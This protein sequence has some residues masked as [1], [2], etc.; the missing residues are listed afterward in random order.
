MGHVVAQ[1]G[2]VEAVVA[3]HLVVAVE[4]TRLLPRLIYHI[5]VDVRIIR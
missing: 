5:V 3:G 4:L 1:L 2:G